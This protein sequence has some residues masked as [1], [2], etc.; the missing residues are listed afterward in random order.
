MDEEKEADSRSLD[1]LESGEPPPAKAWAA[2]AGGLTLDL[3]HVHLYEHGDSGSQTPASMPSTPSPLETAKPFP[4]P[5]AEREASSS[6]TED[7]FLFSDDLSLGESFS[8]TEV[9]HRRLSLCFLSL[10]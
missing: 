7:S 4:G 9:E 10:L 8:G 5:P 1:S 2:K 3:T 6:L